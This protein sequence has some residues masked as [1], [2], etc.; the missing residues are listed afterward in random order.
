[1]ILPHQIAF[2][3]ILLNKFVIITFI[4]TVYHSTVN[5]QTSLLT[6]KA[7]IN[8]IIPLSVVLLN[9]ACLRS[10]F[11]S[12]LFPSFGLPHLE[13]GSVLLSSISVDLLFLLVV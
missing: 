9:Q 2:L 13:C 12:C 4:V 8:L 5:I 3:K 10:F 1:M 7:E 6:A 11:L